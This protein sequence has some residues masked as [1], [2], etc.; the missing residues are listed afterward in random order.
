MNY[1]QS[2]YQNNT[3]V[4]QAMIPNVRHKIKFLSMY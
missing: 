2:Q 3:K 4:T 1:K